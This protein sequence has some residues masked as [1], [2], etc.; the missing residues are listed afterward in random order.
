MRL[1]DK[2]QARKLNMYVKKFEKTTRH[3]SPIIV[4]GMGNTDLAII[5][6]SGALH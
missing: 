1:T 5:N 4:F 2:C 3:K 6:V